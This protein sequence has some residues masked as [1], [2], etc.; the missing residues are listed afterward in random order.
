L[1]DSGVD[2]PALD[3]LIARA[4]GLICGRTGHPDIVD[5][6]VALHARQ[7]SHAVVTADPEDISTVDPTLR[8]I[9]V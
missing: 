5:V 7:Y 1:A 9:T 2:V 8:V 6:H 3:E 4:V